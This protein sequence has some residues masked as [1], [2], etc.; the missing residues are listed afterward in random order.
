MIMPPVAGRSNSRATGCSGDESGSGSGSEGEGDGCSRCA[1]LWLEAL[2]PLPLSCRVMPVALPLPQSMNSRILTASP[3]ADSSA[4][5]GY[6]LVPQPQPPIQPLLTVLQCNNTTGYSLH[7]M[8]QH[9]GI[10]IPLELNLTVAQH[11]PAVFSGDLL[12]VTDAWL[13]PPP[14]ASR[15]HCYLEVSRCHTIIS[16]T[17]APLHP[18]LPVSPSNLFSCRGFVDAITSASTASG[19]PGA[20]VRV[21]Y[22][23]VT[24]VCKGKPEQ[25]VTNAFLVI[26]DEDALASLSWA[27]C[28]SEVHLTH[29]KPKNVSGVGKVFYSTP[30]TRCML[31]SVVAAPL[32][33]ESSL[34][35]LY[36]AVITGCIC[37]GM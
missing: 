24:A 27:R 14:S 4:L 12:L 30:S 29:L 25:K 2:L 17:T 8:T 3:G 13:V 28:S 35:T 32:S 20:L 9:D 23:A 1:P 26:E 22:A 19:R 21:C 37:S 10:G 36:K 11:C 34:A 33:S 18:Q 15:H 31:P 16:A 6:V 7:L 5:L